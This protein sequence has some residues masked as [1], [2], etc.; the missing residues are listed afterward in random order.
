MSWLTTLKDD[1]NRRTLVGAASSPSIPPYDDEFAAPGSVA[2]HYD[3]RAPRVPS[4]RANPDRSQQEVWNAIAARHP[5]K[6]V[7][8][9]AYVKWLDR[10]ERRY[11]KRILL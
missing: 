10:M 2:P 9:L 5:R 4:P 3:Y 7:K 11:E 8:A 6:F 1:M